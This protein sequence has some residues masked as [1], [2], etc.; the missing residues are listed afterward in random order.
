VLLAE[1]L[2]DRWTAAIAGA[3]RQ[4]Q[5]QCR[6]VRLRHFPDT[7]SIDLAFGADALSPCSTARSD[8]E[9]QRALGP[10][11]ARNELADPRTQQLQTVRMARRLTQWLPRRTPVA[12]GT[13][14]A[15][16]PGRDATGPPRRRSSS[17]ASCPGR[18][19]S[20]RVR[21]YLSFTVTMDRATDPDDLLRHRVVGEGGSGPAAGGFLV[22]AHLG[23]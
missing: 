15:V 19:A 2:G 9:R 22:G 20:G 13:D 7:L 23:S 17:P 3:L 18:L 14:G 4:G 5:V 12:A 1:V 21:H 8:R 10:M 16:L 6:S 11:A